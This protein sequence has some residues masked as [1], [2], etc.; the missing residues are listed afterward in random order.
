MQVAFSVLRARCK[1][2]SYIYLNPL[3]HSPSKVDRIWG[4]WGSYSSMPKAMFYLPKRDYKSITQ[5]CSPTFFLESMRRENAQRD[6]PED[7]L[8]VVQGLGVLGCRG[9][10]R[11][12]PR[13]SYAALR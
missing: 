9:W 2:Y 4:I 12:L 13:L 10:D 7:K 1:H 11:R 5:T 8:M 6:G 3:G